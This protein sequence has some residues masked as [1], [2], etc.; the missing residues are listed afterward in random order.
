MPCIQCKG[1]NSK[2][3]SRWFGKP[4][5]R[6][7]SSSFLG[8]SLPGNPSLGIAEHSSSHPGVRTSLSQSMVSSSRSPGLQPTQAMDH[9]SVQPYCRSINNNHISFSKSCS[10]LIRIARS[11]VPKGMLLSWVNVRS[12]M[13]IE[14][15]LQIPSKFERVVIL[16]LSMKWLL[17]LIIPHLPFIDCDDVFWL[18]WIFGLVHPQAT[19]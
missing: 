19:H 10:E 9:S 18:N 5:T 1:V 11:R 4:C 13:Q 2:P 16:C 17:G 7:Q 14:F 8:Q 6:R 12:Y 3:G 15:P